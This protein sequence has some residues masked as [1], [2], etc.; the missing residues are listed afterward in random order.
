MSRDQGKL[1]TEIEKHINKE[2]PRIEGPWVVDRPP[3][4]PPVGADPISHGHGAERSDRRSRGGRDRQRADSGKSDRRVAG[5]QKPAE[6]KPPAQE[7]VE[8]ARL[9]DPV[10]EALGLRPVRRT[11]GSRFR[12]SRRGRR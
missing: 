5:E 7:R 4:E 12:Q 2:L 3:L 8:D 11:L 10:F 1:L 6:Q 9:R